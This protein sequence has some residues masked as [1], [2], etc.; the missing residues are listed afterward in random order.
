MTGA[1]DTASDVLAGCTGKVPYPAKADAH[2]AMGRM[3]RRKK[4]RGYKTGERV[5]P[6]RCDHC[7]A[8]HLG[9]T[10]RGQ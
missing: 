5:F 4:L 10:A 3:K 1:P 6:Y 7:G 8:W 9:A 2:H